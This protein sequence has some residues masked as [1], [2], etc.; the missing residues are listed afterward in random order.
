MKLSRI[1]FIFILFFVFVPS[2]ASAQS[3][4]EKSWKPFYSAFRVAVRKHDRTALKAMMSPYFK[5]DTIGDVEWEKR[6]GKL[7]RRLIA[8]KYYD[9]PDIK[10]WAKLDK[11]LASG[12][13]SIKHVDVGETSGA[14]RYFHRSASISINKNVTWFADFETDINGNWK[15]KYF[16]MQGD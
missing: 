14:V 8:F 1:S 15:W 4:A 16:G 11:V 12:L 7:D 10:G 3:A 6:F 2:I 13:S 5:Y 9:R